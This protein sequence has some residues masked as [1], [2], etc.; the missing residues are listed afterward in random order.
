MGFEWNVFCPVNTFPESPVSSRSFHCAE[1]ARPRSSARAFGI[2]EIFDKSN[3]SIRFSKSSSF[4]AG[5]IG[6]T[7]MAFQ[8]AESVS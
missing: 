3:A 6:G 1:R 2:R 8:T 5:R 7:V 4:A